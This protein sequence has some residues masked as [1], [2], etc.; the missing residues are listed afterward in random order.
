[1]SNYEEPKYD[2]WLVSNSLFK[3]SLAVMGH[4]IIGTLLIYAPFVLLWF[5]LMM[6]SIP[7]AIMGG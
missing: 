1:M 4:S 6:L 3:R 5:I 2:G 7:F